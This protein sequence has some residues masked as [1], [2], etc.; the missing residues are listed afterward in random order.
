MLSSDIC[1]YRA[2]SWAAALC[3]YGPIVHTIPSCHAMENQVKKPLRQTRR[4][5]DDEQGVQQVVQQGGESHD[6]EAE[7]KLEDALDFGVDFE[8]D[9][10]QPWQPDM[11]GE[12]ASDA[13]DEAS[14]EAVV[15]TKPK[16]S[17]SSSSRSRPAQVPEPAVKKKP[18]AAVKPRG[19]VALLLPK[20]SPFVVAKAGW[21]PP[22]GVPDVVDVTADSDKES[23]QEALASFQGAEEETEARKVLRRET[24]T[25]FALPTGFFARRAQERREG[26]LCQTQQY[27]KEFS[28]HLNE[29]PLCAP[30]KWYSNIS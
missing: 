10:E 8:E 26:Q 1:V 7:D 27:Q 14:A 20:A 15:T 3:F 30:S 16:A 5:A 9:S 29:I 2:H 19:T 18:K 4:K 11:D 23:T 25:A 22:K 21:I 13:S 12:A 28:G 17:S 24:E 6:D